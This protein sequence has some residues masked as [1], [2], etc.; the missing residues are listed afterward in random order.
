M[1]RLVTVW[2][3]FVGAARVWLL[4]TA[5]MNGTMATNGLRDV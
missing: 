5:R 1:A 4:A 2:L 3:R